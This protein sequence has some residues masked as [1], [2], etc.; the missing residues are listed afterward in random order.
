M[1]L[2][3]DRHNRVHNLTAG[4]VERVVYALSGEVA[5]AQCEPDGDRIDAGKDAWLNIPCPMDYLDLSR[6]I[7]GYAELVE[8][9]IA[10]R[11]AEQAAK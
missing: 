9:F 6:S 5:S 8:G 3:C 11:R 1:K 4:E 7:E 2:W 10:G